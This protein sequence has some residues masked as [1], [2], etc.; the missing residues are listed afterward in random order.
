MKFANI[1]VDISHEKLDRPFGYIIPKELEDKISIGTQIVIPFGKGN[2]E[3]TGYVIEITDKPSFDI[4][5]MK[6]IIRANEGA[7]TV[8]KQ[9]IELAWWIKKEYS[10]TMNQALKTVIPVKKKIKNIQKKRTYKKQNCSREK[11]QFCF[12][13]FLLS[14]ICQISSGKRISL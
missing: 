6:Y 4:N 12:F 5:K 10:C 3:I 13:K 2:R 1:I 11:R 9:L 7:A 8:E 14:D